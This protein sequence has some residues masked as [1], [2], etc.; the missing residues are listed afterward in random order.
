VFLL[1]EAWGGF[2]FRKAIT[3]TPHAYTPQAVRGL[4]F[5]PPDAV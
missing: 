3:S 1:G 4:T 5:L 2:M